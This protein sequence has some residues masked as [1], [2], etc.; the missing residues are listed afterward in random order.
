M[1]FRTT[2]QI[3]E[4]AG[5]STGRR[6][7]KPTVALA[8][9]ATM[10]LLA[11]CGH[12][13]SPSADSG[14]ATTASATTSTTTDEPGVFGTLARICEPGSGKATTS[15]VRGVTDSEIRIGVLNDAGN[16]LSPGLGASYPKVA[17]AFAE[18]C[19]DA[20]GI[21]GRKIVIVDRDAKLF[22]AAAQIVDACKTDF[23][24][25]GG[26]AALDEPTIEP[27]EKCKLGSIP[28]LNASYKDQVSDLQAVVGRTS[29]TA[30][31]WGLFRLLEPKYADAFK[32]IGII[33]LDT[34]DVRGPYEKFAKVLESK[35][36]DVTS[37]QAISQNLDNARTY[38]Q[39]LVGKA[40][41]LVLAFPAT[42]IF[43]AMKDVGYT[44][45][46]IV[47]QGSAFYN[48]SAVGYLAKVPTDAPIYSAANTYPLDLAADNPTAAKVVEL[49]KAAFGKPDPANVVPWITWLLF[50]KS[51]SACTDL[52]VDCVIDKATSDPAY[53]AGGLLAPT[54]MTD[55]AEVTPCLAVNTVSAKGISYDR[56]LTDPDNGVFNCDSANVIPIP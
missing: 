47:D 17:K 25:V 16:N 3:I 27:R 4:R 19:N 15:D 53:T 54:D 23:M 24:L 34:P 39:P 35:G 18:W 20:G 30:S 6:H 37:T 26:G 21:N 11:G 32:K 49:E 40:D 5:R 12:S 43:Q 2:H 38:I 50:A 10:T 28:A 33:S 42:E 44:P 29:Q 14:S 9:V 55:P 56:E 52:T 51:A 45:D 8:L 36:L 7:P 22:D 1:P 41:T 48:N 13:S 46:V 31:N